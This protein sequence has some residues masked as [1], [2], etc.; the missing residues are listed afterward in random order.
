MQ[1][2]YLLSCETEAFSNLIRK[3]KHTYIHTHKLDPY[4]WGLDLIFMNLYNSLS[5]EGLLH[6]T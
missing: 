2:P 4:L 6:V 3:Y 5:P 1:L